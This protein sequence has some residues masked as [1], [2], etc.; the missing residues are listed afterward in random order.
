MPDVKKYGK[1]Y[2]GNKNGI[3]ERVNGTEFIS[4]TFF[5]TKLTLPFEFLKKNCTIEGI[6][7]IIFSIIS[8]VTMINVQHS[9][10]D[11]L[12]NGVA[13][14]LILIPRSIYFDAEFG[15]FLSLRNSV[16]KIS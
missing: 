14:S 13:L 16:S 2:F 1:N 6:I 4:A 15:R 9:P 8:C 11:L 10:L 5:A 3:R 7:K 12:Q